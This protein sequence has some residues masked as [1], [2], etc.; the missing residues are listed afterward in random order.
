MRG[1]GVLGF[2]KARVERER[3]EEVKKKKTKILSSF[4]ARLGEEEEGTVS[5]KM[6]LFCSFKKKNMKRRRFGQ[7][8]SLPNFN[9]RP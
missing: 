8:A 2:G 3:Q 9:H 7:N 4:A 5:L 1:R 6:T